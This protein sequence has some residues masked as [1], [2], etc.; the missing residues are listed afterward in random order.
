M[1]MKLTHKKFLF[2]G[3][4]LAVLFCLSGCSKSERSIAKEISDI[5]SCFDSY[6]LELTDYNI[7]KRQT[8]NEDKTD[9]IWI[10]IKGENDDLSYSASYMATYIKYNDGWHLEEYNLITNSYSANNKPD[11]DEIK[12][13]ISNDYENI[14]L[15]GI[16][17]PIGETNKAIYKFM[18]S[19]TDNY[20]VKYYEI[21]VTYVFSLKNGW[22]QSQIKSDIIRSDY[23]NVLGE[24]LYSDAGHS[25]Y[26]HITEADEN[27]FTF[28]YSFYNKLSEKYDDFWKLRESDYEEYKCNFFDNSTLYFDVGWKHK[29]TD[30][31]FADTSVIWF[32]NNEVTVKGISGTGIVVNGYYLHKISNELSDVNY[33]KENIEIKSSIVVD[34]SSIPN[35]LF[36]STLVGYLEYLKKSYSELGFNTNKS[37]NTSGTRYPL[38]KADFAGKSAFVSLWFPMSYDEQSLPSH[39]EI[40]VPDCSFNDLLDYFENQMKMDIYKES[41]YLVYI[42]VP[43]TDIKIE[44]L[45][46]TLSPNI[47]IS[48]NE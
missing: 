24:W 23:S 28:E 4:L 10:T 35:S 13:V 11:A 36:D 16:D 15:I 32:C 27:G 8:N 21:R 14:S 29:F 43:N 33:P 7:E 3:I 38:Q 34:Y 45:E 42:L 6:N 18:G 47:Y 17:E 37:S 44:I 39:L 2:I 19:I 46:G 25:Y 30:I 5:D 31:S 9:Y 22:E 40:T 12:N 20:V 1:I 41:T 48:L 26:I